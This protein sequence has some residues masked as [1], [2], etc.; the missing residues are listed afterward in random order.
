MPPTLNNNG[1]SGSPPHTPVNRNRFRSEDSHFLADESKHQEIETSNNLG[2]PTNEKT[3]LIDS[4]NSHNNAHQAR[5]DIS[6]KLYKRRGGM[7]WNAE[8]NWYAFQNPCLF[9]RVCIVQQM[10]D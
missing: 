2:T 6:D 9:H 8:H 3:P 10:T 4:L 7:G 5:F 1:Y